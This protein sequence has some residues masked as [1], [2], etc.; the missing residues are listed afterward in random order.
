MLQSLTNEL[1]ANPHVGEGRLPL[2]TVPDQYLL[3]FNMETVMVFQP[4]EDSNEENRFI[5]EVL[6]VI[7]VC[8][9]FGLPLPSNMNQPDNPYDLIL[10]SGRTAIAKHG[11][12]SGDPFLIDDDHTHHLHTWEVGI[13]VWPAGSNTFSLECWITHT[14]FWEKC[15]LHVPVD[16]R[17][18]L[19][20][21]PEEMSSFDELVKF[22][23]QFGGPAEVN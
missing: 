15:R 19:M 20:V 8:K 12:H 17:R 16:G 13:L 2:S 11:A 23:E 6:A 22:E 3:R 7:A 1:V 5:N 9:A 18:S 10:P 21:T 14:E 4:E